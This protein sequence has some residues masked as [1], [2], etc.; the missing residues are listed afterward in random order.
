[1]NELSGKFI[2]IDG[3]DGSGKT[4]Q[5]C[6][7]KARLEEEGYDVAIADF[8]QY[9]TKSAGLVEE[10]LS[11]KYGQAEEVNSYQA[12]IFYAVDRY[13]ASFKIRQWLA[14]GKIVLANRYTS[15]NMG[16]QGGK[17]AN[18]LERKVFFN[19]LYDLE[20]KIF[21]IPRPDLSIILHVESAIAQEL[22]KT[23]ARE[24]WIGKKA[25]IHEDN[26]DHLKKAELIYLEIANSF[27][28]FRLI[29]CTKN[30][31]ILSREEI[32]L[33][34]WPAV[35]KIIAGD[36][37][38][39]RDFQAIGNIIGS[40]RQIVDNREII[41]DNRQASEPIIKNDVPVIKNNLPAK[42][43]IEKVSPQA[44]LPQ[45]AHSGDAGYDLYANNYYS[46]PPY[47]Q[48]LV[49]SG[50]KMVIPEGY[51]GLIWDKSGLAFRGIK[52]MGGVIDSNYRGEIK[53]V[54]KNLSEDDFNIIPG[55]KIAQI[56]IQ[57]VLDLE[58]SEEPII[59]ETE[60]QA[61]GFGSSGQ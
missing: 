44:K 34:I 25:D 4:T 58:I 41:F 57:P 32:S 16:H 8:P 61:S 5:L 35:K 53:M 28:D 39:S 36:I 2:V 55:Q 24:E 11:G 27:P 10:Y 33:L 23:R 38:Q 60:R 17:I 59:D 50:V 51:V 45:K 46:I 3:T 15:A 48:D 52:M 43:I 9:N 18:P 54:V 31:A 42:L 20:Y 1:M 30:N 13:D 19:W 21:E 26:L 6:L 12:S 29:S 47:G 37:F 7:L 14:E 22:A 49:G 56:L 40:N